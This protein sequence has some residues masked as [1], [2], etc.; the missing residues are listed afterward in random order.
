MD[1]FQRPVQWILSVPNINDPA[2]VS[3]LIIISPFEANGLISEVRQ[4][5][6]VTLHLYSPLPNLAYK[7]LDDLDLYTMGRS[8]VVGSVPRS[9]IVQ[10]NLFAGQLYLRSYAEYV[11][12]CDFLGLAW[13]VAKDGQLVRGMCSIFFS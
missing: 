3:R 8:F 4:S 13:S 2:A 7:A 9:L 12:L 11:E 10:L 6:K 5:A 1:S